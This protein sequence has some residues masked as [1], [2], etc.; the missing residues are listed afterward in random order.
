[1]KKLAK[2]ITTQNVTVGNRRLAQAISDHFQFFHS[3]S[4]MGGTGKAGRA[5]RCPPSGIGGGTN[6]ALQAGGRQ[7]TARH[8]G[9]TQ[10]E[11]GDFAAVE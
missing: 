2:G 10:Y 9:L 11:A 1:V 8:A 6:V 4:V 5:L 7:R 3:F